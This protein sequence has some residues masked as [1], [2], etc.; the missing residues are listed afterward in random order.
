MLRDFESVSIP[1]RGS[2][3]L[4]FSLPPGAPLAAP[5]SSFREKKNR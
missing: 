4:F 1:E 2:K 5:L 3:F